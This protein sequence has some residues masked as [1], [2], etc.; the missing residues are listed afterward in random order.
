M[1]R[2]SAKLS[3]SLRKGLLFTTISVLIFGFSGCVQSGALRLSLPDSRVPYDQAW[4]FTLEA[5]LLFHDRIVIEDKSAGF[6][7]TS[8]DIHQ[9][10][11]VIGTPVKRSRLIGRV[12]SQDPFRLN[13]DMEQEAFSLELGRWVKDAPDRNRLLEIKER[14]RV[15]LRL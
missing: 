14:L 10:G 9:V 3:A 6:F 13:I 11:V 12:V 2:A 1:K 5:S 15:R 8:W 7:Q 4:Q